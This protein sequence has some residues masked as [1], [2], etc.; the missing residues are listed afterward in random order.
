[1]NF[2]TLWALYANK[3]RPVDPTQRFLPMQSELAIYNSSRLYINL[4]A[5][6]N[7]LRGE[8]KEFFGTHGRDGRNNSAQSRFPCFYDKVQT[9]ACLT[10]LQVCVGTIHHSSAPAS[11][12]SHT[13]FDCFAH[14]YS[15]M[16]IS[17]SHR[18]YTTQL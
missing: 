9:A 13:L 3:T 18:G 4:D 10:V 2:T 5:C 14:T 8:C 11:P 16:L 1:M 6:V 15:Y 12:S 7:T 17:F